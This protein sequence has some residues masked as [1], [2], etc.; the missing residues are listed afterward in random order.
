MRM[1][2][3]EAG[4]NLEWKRRMRD[5]EKKKGQAQAHAVDASRMRRRNRKLRKASIQIGSTR[6]RRREI[7]IQINSSVLFLGA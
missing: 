5:E 4:Y 6:P 2:S 3:Y 1:A 7:I